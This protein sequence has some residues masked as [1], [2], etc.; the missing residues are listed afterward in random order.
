MG[1]LFVDVTSAFASMV[2]RFVVLAEA[3]QSDEELAL[4][5]VRLASRPPKPPL[6]LMRRHRTCFGRRTELDRM[7]L[8]LRPPCTRTRGSAQK[9]CL[10]FWRLRRARLPGPVAYTHLPLPR[11][12][13][14]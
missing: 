7:R 6:P 2:R 8:H 10:E 12:M 9:A 4:T 1:A 13:I 3:Y 11:K 5:L 14:V